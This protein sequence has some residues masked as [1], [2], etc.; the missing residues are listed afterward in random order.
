VYDENKREKAMIK[1]LIPIFAA[2]LL[3]ACGG[4]AA[5]N[6]FMSVC[7]NSGNIARKN[8]Q[9]LAVEATKALPED[10]L[11][12]LTTMILEDEEQLQQLR[13][14]LAPD[15]WKQLYSFMM[16]APTTCDIDMDSDV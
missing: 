2:V 11:A 15:Q 16:T 1:P 14:S 6:E 10:G 7:E 12:W 8:C 4:G 9:C 5:K 13:A 3:T